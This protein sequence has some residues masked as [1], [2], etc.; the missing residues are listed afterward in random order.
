MEVGAGAPTSNL[1]PPTA[2]GGMNKRKKVAWRKHRVRG[3]KREEQRKL[4][5]LAR[6]KR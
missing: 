2:E 5:V 6:G 4:G 1:Q 3:K